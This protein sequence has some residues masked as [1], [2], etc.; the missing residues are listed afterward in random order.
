MTLRTH[1]KL[2]LSYSLLVAAVVVILTIG[3]DATVRRP[4]LDQAAIELLR[5]VALGREIYDADTLSTADASARRLS[6]ITGHRVTIIAPDGTV[7]GD[8]DVAPVHLPALENHGNRPEVR[9]AIDSGT[10]TA[11]RRSTSVGTELLYAAGTTRRGAVIRFAVGIE[12]I[13][14]VVAAVR[15][16]VLQVGALAL[17]MAALFSL[18]F[19][20]LITRP[21]RRMRHIAA[22]MSAGD[23][24]ARTR[25]RRGDELGEL[26]AALDTLAAELQHRLAQL[27][28]ERE[29]MGALI[30]AMAEGVLALAPDGSVRRVNPAAMKMFDLPGDAVGLPPEAVSRSSGFLELVRRVLDGAAVEPTTLRHQR[31]QLLATA[32]P[33]PRGGAVLVFLDMTEVRR[34]EG[35][36]REFVANASHELKTPLTAIRGYSE[37]LLD[38]GIP[39]ELRQRFTSAIHSN[40]QRLQGILDDLLDLSQIESGGWPLHP[41]AVHLADAVRD[42]WQQFADAA[43]AKDVSFRTDIHADCE[44]VDADPRALR[45]VFTNLF[46]NALRY[47]PPGGRIE[48]RA[49]PAGTSTGG[50]GDDG[51]VGGGDGVGGGARIEVSDTGSGIAAQHLDRIFERFYRADPARSRAEGGTGLGLAIVRHLIERHGGSIEAAS[52]LGRGTTIRF[53]LPTQAAEPATESAS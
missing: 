38:A 18:A 19:S 28:M 10:G 30:D 26:G 21:L 48:V 35:V 24:T 43:G 9:A 7:L 42:A 11:V 50:V 46:S 13:D 6:G 40:A 32:Q 3:V 15:R 31:T 49:A 45:Q 33:L 16:Q 17:L 47:T 20:F 51:S 34:L 53:T 27:E 2:F 29:E 36:R 52:E 1:Y 22:T 44:F 37:T 14:D 23:L 39:A 25:T 12:T 41:E 8:S 4:L 5:E